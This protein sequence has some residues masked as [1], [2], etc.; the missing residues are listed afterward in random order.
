M[1]RSND[2]AIKS[3]E[4][5]LGPEERLRRELLVKEVGF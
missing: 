4:S 1:L 2:P 3:T 5:V